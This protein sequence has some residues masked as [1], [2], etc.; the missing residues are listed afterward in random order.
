[1]NEAVNGSLDGAAKTPWHLWAI[2][3]ISLLWNAGGGA[4]DYIQVHLEVESYLAQ[5][6]E[7]VG[8]TVAQIISYYDAFPIWANISWALG[9][10]GAVA[11]SVLLLLR[12]RFAF[13]AFIVSLF[14]LIV[15]TLHTQSSPMPIASDPALAEAA[16]TFQ[17]VFAAVIWIVTLL[18]IYYAR[19]M[20]KAGVLR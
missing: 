4:S 15:T 18:L 6:A 5:G 11:G 20:T 12:S 8:I 10:W 2:G 13:H 16:G 7:M 1:M 14:G 3:I 17:L 9:V 19:R